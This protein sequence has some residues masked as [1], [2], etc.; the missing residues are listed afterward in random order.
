MASASVSRRLLLSVAVPLVLFFGVTVVVIDSV[1]RNLSAMALHD[2]LEE[3]IVALITAVELGDSG[4]IEVNLLD[5]ES[6]LDQPLSGQYAAVQQENGVLLW[7]SPSLSG[8]GLSL[9]G[10]LPVGAVQFRYL[11]TRGGAQVAELSRGLQWEYAP[12]K[13]KNLV[14]TAAVSTA[15]QVRQLA[16]FRQELIGWFALLALALLA[17]LAGLVRLALAPVRRLEQEIGEVELGVQPRLGSQ[18]PREL[19]GVANNLNA[20][21]QAERNRIARYRDTL[22]NLAHS[23]K[24]PLAVIR[25]HLTGAASESIVGIERE[26]DRIAGIVD[27]QL[28]RAA[29]S[30]GVTLG[31]MAIPVAVVAAELRTA[32]L[33]VHARKDLII[34]LDIGAEVGFLGDRGDLTEVLGNLLDN[35]C[36]WCRTRVRVS[37]HIEL[38]RVP[39][40]RLIVVVEDDG[41][42]IAPADRERVIERGVRIDEQVPGHGLG[43]AMVRETASLYGGRLLIDTSATLGG[44]RVE[45][46][47]PGR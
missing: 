26:I 31:Q 43:L 11:D 25:A 37:A 9:G 20:L 12:D 46:Q 23:L 15:P 2:V 38:Q 27:H 30:T 39:T 40:R 29:T 19:A 10:A 6:R 34:D 1:F 24:T 22:G 5:P 45:L 36:K 47:L 21:L 3:Q 8:T 7:N 16:R 17:T 42:G 13:S 33:K 35:G 41:S 4:E 44:A 32:L 18:Y 28:Q 14:F